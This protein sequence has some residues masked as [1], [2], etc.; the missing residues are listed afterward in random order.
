MGS[1]VFKFS[2]EVG[3]EEVRSA[4]KHARVKDSALTSTEALAVLG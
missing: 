1:E 2:I 4:R 3:E